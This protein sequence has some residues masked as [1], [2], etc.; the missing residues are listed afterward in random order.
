[1]QVLVIGGTRF[2]GYGLVWRLLLEGHRV[3][4]LTRGRTS[5]PFGNRVERLVAD[6]TSTGFVEAVRGRHFHAA[7]DFLV[8]TGDEA[9]GAVNALD[10]DHYVMVSTGSVYLVRLNCPSPSRE[11]DYEGPVMPEPPTPADEPD[12]RYSV[13]K[14]AAE[15]VL[16]EAWE[17][18][19]FPSTRVRIPIVNGERD[20]SGRLESYLRRILDGGPLVLPDGGARRLRHVYSGAVAEAI[21]AMLGQQQV[22]GQAYNI[23]QDE[24]PTLAEILH[25]VAEEMGA[26]LRIV[27]VSEELMRAA[28]LERD[29]VFPFTGHWTSILDPG[30][31]KLELGFR[32]PPLRHYLGKIVAS[33]MA[34]I[35]E[36]P[37]AYYAQR[38]KELALAA[39]VGG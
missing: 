33:F 15:D 29:R 35:P 36:Q 12:W 2:V 14:R 1:M 11:S 20:Y 30:K 27:A 38:A 7:V 28:G 17:Q 21:M 25:M 5:D 34:A 22:L 39:E 8:Y 16:L 6:R 3:T 23:T 4:I 37:P 18:K 32:H 13:G 26:P 31:A 24:I 10:T 9:R 19:R